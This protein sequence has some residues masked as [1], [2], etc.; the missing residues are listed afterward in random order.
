MQQTIHRGLK[1]WIGLALWGGLATAGSAMAD[2]V[3][4]GTVGANGG[5][6]SGSSGSSLEKPKGNGAPAA[7]PSQSPLK[8]TQP[9]AVISKHTIEETQAPS[10]NYSSIIAHTP[11]V[12][13]VSP[14]GPGLQENAG[15]SIR[16]F[17]DGEFNVTF[18]GIP[19]GDSNDFTHH[20]TSYFMPQDIG[21]IAVERGPGNAST[22]GT[23]TFGGTVAVR[24]KTPSGSAG[25]IPYAS[26]GSFNTRL[27]GLEFDSGLLNN[28]GGARAF[29]DYKHLTSNGYLTY[30]GLR[31]DNV[32]FKVQRPVGMNSVVTLVAMYNRL[33][34]NVNNQ[35]VTKAQIAQFGPNFAL[36]NNPG[37][38]A[39]YGYNYDDIQSDFEYLG[40]RSAFGGGWS[41]DD[42]LYTYYYNHHGAN[43]DD[44]TVV[45]TA[46][47][48]EGTTYSPN[49]VL[50]QKMTMTYRSVGNILRLAKRL[51][52]G[53]VRTGLWTDHQWNT[54]SEY[55]VDW[56]LG[57]AQDPSGKTGAYNRLMWDTLDSVQP[58]AEFAWK[59]TAALTVTPGLKYAWFKRGLNAQV[60]QKTGL[61]ADTSA[62][63][64]SLLPSLDL[65][66][67]L[68]PD[69]SAYL[70][71]A[72][73]YLAPNLNNFYTSNPAFPQPKP[74]TTW[75][76]QL[77][78][79]WHND[80]VTADADVYY[81]NFDNKVGHTGSG[82]TLTYYNQG[83][84]TY[85]GVEGEATVALAAGF[86]L[87]GNLSF[88]SAKK[89]D[90]GLTIAYT[91][92]HTATAGLLYRDLA[93]MSASW[94]TEW[95]GRTY[96]DDT[97]TD[98]VDPYTVSDLS[99][100][101]RLPQASFLH[102]LTLGAQLHNVFNSHNI[103]LSHGDGTYWTLPGRSLFVNVSVKL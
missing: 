67:L 80:R 6:S 56:T 35:G 88:I 30:S 75:N 45:G 37:S 98:R 103:A 44:T 9:T 47:D 65:R 66:Y 84:V 43:G 1:W 74:E 76:Y 34:Q 86:S 15:V 3:D 39:Y 16:G 92:D 19:W 5:G 32:F 51:G 31:R 49:D 93:G 22:I 89:K 59:P 12:I 60:N 82:S 96:G 71:T 36:N 17:Q 72:K 23:A 8:I 87:Y 95:I 57:G 38:E 102:D 21:S 11:S 94:M 48:P 54:R 7:A 53:I 79:V 90:T 99:V 61:P 42:K 62:T 50:G 81:I 73:G 26:I 101:Y 46:G 40:L 18:D 58:Y 68:Q 78:T 83:G 77:G 63:Y 24:S 100:N 29:L 20:S 55:N 91:P 13:S 4:L 33:H 97:E 69:W 14:N 52:P 2:P 64:H 10:A 28:A 85:K 27:E 41:L 25:I 70:Q